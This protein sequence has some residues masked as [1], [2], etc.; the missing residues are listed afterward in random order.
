MTKLFAAITLVVLLSACN[1]V[2]EAQRRW[3]AEQLK[4]TDVM[5]TS[6]SGY[7]GAARL[8]TTTKISFTDP[9]T[10]QAQVVTDPAT[11]GEV[12][13]LVAGAGSRSAADGTK[14]TKSLKLTLTLDPSEREV[15]LIYFPDKD[16]ISLY[17]VPNVPWPQHYVGNYAVVPEF[18]AAL[19]Q[20]LND[21]R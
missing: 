20:I 14:P 21:T 18:G 16:R 11:I 17:N 12:L 4:H 5:P 3:R 7:I 9:A 15:T 1:P 8:D 10:G 19:A 6:A 13:R 2:E